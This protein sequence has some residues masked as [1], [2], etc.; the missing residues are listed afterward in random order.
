VAN[1]GRVITHK[2]LLRDVWGPTMPS[3]ATTCAFTWGTYGK[4]SKSTRLCRSICWPKP[5]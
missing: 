2:Q 1:V 5:G 3:R 4:N